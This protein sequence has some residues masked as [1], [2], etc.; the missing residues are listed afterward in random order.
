[1]PQDPNLYGQRLPKKRKTEATVS[2]SLAFASQLSS[3]LAADRCSSTAATAS[4][5]RAK[6]KTGSTVVQLKPE[7]FSISKSK[8]DTDRPKRADRDADAREPRKGIVLRDP[9]GTEEDKIERARAR[10]K[11]EAKARLYA[12]MKRGDYIARE[13]EVA[14]LVDFDRKWA[15]AHGDGDRPAG[16]ESSSG[17]DHGTG[18]ENEHEGGAEHQ[19]E[20]KDEIVEWEDEF[21]RLRRGTQA[22]KRRHERRLA[23]SE[24][25]ASELD[26]MS[27]RPRAPKALIVG[28]AVQTS[29][30][31]AR[32]ADA[33]EALARKRDRSATPPELKHYDAGHEIRTR[34]VAFYSFSKDEAARNREMA[35]LEAERANTEAG[36]KARGEKVAARKREMESRR[37]Q[38]AERKAKKMADTFLDGL[39]KEILG[40]G[41]DV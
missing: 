2:T 16:D 3:I 8:R 30:F 28:D 31:V 24:A 39:G 18:D 22:E 29:A 40:E 11:M 6:S 14:P 12:A 5:S 15:E 1:M 26:T 34:G 32:D 9:Q 27:A 41:S 13:G 19:A 20:N 35:E 21:G 17:D 23:R 36:R 38:M 7:L 33:M 4:S 25:A 10:R 37:K